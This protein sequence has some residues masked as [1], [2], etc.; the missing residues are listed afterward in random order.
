V[1]LLRPS[2]AAVVFGALLGSVTAHDP[3]GARRKDQD[4][5]KTYGGLVGEWKGTGQVQRASR[6]GAWIES[7]T[8]A[9]KLSPNAAALE[10]KVKDGK[11]L[12]SAVLKPAGEPS[13]YI[14]DATLSDGSARRFSGK[15]GDRNVLALSAEGEG[16]GLRRITLTPLHDTRLLVLLEAQSPGAAVYQK[17][18]EVGYTRQGVAFAAGDSYPVCIVTEGRGTIQVK[19]QGKTYWVCCSGCK[20]LFDDDPAAVIADAE[21]KAKKNSAG[22]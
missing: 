13:S 15:A 12:K 3:A 20:D 17:L 5:L 18:G 7:A 8:W 21:R 9:W 2:L 4:A 16:E 6:K 11:Y 14:L 22:K 19:Y 10:M 1:T